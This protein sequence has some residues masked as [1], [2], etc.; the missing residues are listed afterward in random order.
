MKQ[1]IRNWTAFMIGGMIGVTVMWLI[2]P[3]PG[4][5]TRRIISENLAGA[6]NKAGMVIGDA[7]EKVRQI[8]DIGRR[9]V[10][11]QVSSIERGAE[12]MKSVAKGS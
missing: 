3:M 7:Q 8:S 9:V 10:E 5:E 2:A 1:L 6:Q 12:E 4:E 11:E